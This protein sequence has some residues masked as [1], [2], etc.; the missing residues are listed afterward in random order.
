M[1]LTALLDATMV[2]VL[3]VDAD[4]DGLADPGDRIA[5]TVDLINF[6]DMDATG[7]GFDLVFDDPNLTLVPGSINVSPLARNDA[8]QAVGNTPLEVG[9]PQGSGPSVN[10]NGSLFDND[11]EFLGD[12]FALTSFDATSAFGGQVSVNPDGTFTYDPPVGFEGTDTFGYSI[13]DATTIGEGTVTIDVLDPVWY[14]DNSASPGGDGT[15]SAPFDDLAPLNSGGAAPDD[16]GDTIFLYEGVS[17]SSPYVGP[18]VLENGQDLVGQAVDLQVGGHVLVPS[19]GRPVVSGFLS[20]DAVE[21]ARDNT[22]RGLRLERANAGIRGFDVGTLSIDDVEISDTT[23]GIRANGGPT[24][25]VTIDGVQ[26]SNSGIA[27]LLD[28]GG[29]MSASITRNFLN[30]VST[31]IAFVTNTA[32]ITVDDLRGN[33]IE[34]ASN[35]GI[36][37]SGL[38]GVVFNS[39]SGGNTSISGPGAGIIVPR[40]S[41]A[42]SFDALDIRSDSGPALVAGGIGAFSLNVLDG[43]LE[44]LSDTALDLFNLSANLSTTLLSAGGDDFG[45]RLTSVDG[46]IT[47]TTTTVD[48]ALDTAVEILNSPA[49]IDLG[50]LTIDSLGADGLSVS[51][52]GS[53]RTTGGTIETGNGIG[54]DINNAELDVT[55]ESVA[56]TG[57]THGIRLDTTTGSFSVTGNGA[58]TTYV[59][60][61]DSTNETELSRNS[62]GGVFQN[63]TGH[64]VVLDD[65][66]GVTLRQM[67]LSSTGGDAIFS[68]GGGDFT[69]EALEIDMASHTGNGWMAT[70]LGGAN[71]LRGSVIENVDTAGRSSIRVSNT[72]TLLEGLDVENNTFQESQSGQS[73]V[74][75]ESSGSG[76][77]MDVGLRGNRF[78]NNTAQA[79]TGSAGQSAGSATLTSRVGGPNAGDGN[80]FGNTIPGAL[81]NNIG[82]LVANGATHEAL[83]QGNLLDDVARDGG[84]ANTSIIRTQNNGG[85]AIYEV[86]DN[87]LQNFNFTSGGRHGIGHV[88][89]PA[90]GT[91]YTSLIVDS[92]TIDDTTDREGIFI[93]FRRNMTGGD[94]TISN[95]EIGL[96]G[97]V[98]GGG[99][100]SDNEAIDIEIRNDAGL[101]YTVNLLIEQNT[102]TTTASGSREIVFVEA[103]DSTSIEATIRNNMITAGGTGNEIEVE[104]E[105]LGSAVHASISGNT[106]ASGTGRIDLDGGSGVLR[107]QQ[108][109]QSNVASVN[110][111][112][113]GNVIISGGGV[114]QFSAGSPELPSHPMISSARGLGSASAASAVDGNATSSNENAAVSDPEPA[115]AHGTSATSDGGFAGNG[116]TDISIPIGVLPPGQGVQ[117]FFEADVAS[118]LNVDAT[119]VAAQGSVTADGGISI[120]T[121]D[122]DVVGLNATVTPL[123]PPAAVAQVYVSSSRWSQSFLEEVDPDFELKNRMFVIP[124]DGS[125]DILEIDP[126]SGTELNRFVAPLPAASAS[127]GL[128]FDG[129]SLFFIRGLVS[130]VLWELDPDT[131]AVIDQDD[132]GIVSIDGIAAVGERIY[133]NDWGAGKILE[134]DPVSDTITNTIFPDSQFQGGIGGA[135]N[136]DRLLASFNFGQIL[137]FDLQAQQS[138]PLFFPPFNNVRGVAELDGE[139]YVAGGFGD[140][141]VYSPQGGI[142]RSHPLPTGGLGLAS[143]VFVEHDAVGHPVP[144]GAAQ[145]DRLAWDNVDR[146]HVVFTKDVDVDP[147]AATLLGANVPGGAYPL[148]PNLFEYDPATRTATW[149]LDTSAFPAMPYDFT[150]LE[151]DA[152]LVSDAGGV[153]LLDGDWVNPEA[154]SSG[155]SYPSGDGLAGGNFE[156]RLDF[157]VA[158]ADGDKATTIFD[159]RDVRDAMFTSIGSPAYSVDLDF[160]GNGQI[161][162]QEVQSLRH[163][164]GRLLSPGVPTVPPSRAPSITL[165][166]GQDRVISVPGAAARTGSLDVILTTGD[167]STR[168][169]LNYS[170]RVGLTGPDVGGGVALTGGGVAQTSPAAIAPMLNV[171]GNLDRLPDSYYLGTVNLFEPPLTVADGDGL[172]R[173]D[174]EVQPGALG[175]Y[176]FGVQAGGTADT[177]L[178]VNA[179]NGEELFLIAGS[180]LIVT[181]PGDLDGDFVVG[182][183]DLQIV[184]SNFTQSVPVGDYAFGDHTGPGGIPDGI[185]GADD[186]SLVLSNFTN[187]AVPPSAATEDGDGGQAGA[188]AAW[189][190]W[191]EYRQTQSQ[192]TDLRWLPE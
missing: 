149:G 88:A 82:V 18:L 84:I 14:V 183:N 97:N 103:K 154:G 76:F 10:I 71:V 85:T 8:Y 9:V 108:T 75:V 6:G 26:I 62:S 156:F 180:N 173:V 160:N 49:T 191:R 27:I 29:T 172:I 96:I 50:Q 133:L 41:G 32:A 170:V 87:V 179:S 91:G 43:Q 23:D 177:A 167:G 143:G 40:A 190:A 1:L 182:A 80:L 42:L 109:S 112:S 152:S 55:L 174:Y 59:T 163:Q 46:S 7:T 136:P 86:L 24:A 164:L 110:S 61:V 120:L 22:V 33:I 70:D 72:N 166:A 45:V 189:H 3:V 117:I 16:E 140:L 125:S 5:Y 127:D 48:D 36:Q 168:S 25:A 123:D 65:A 116:A 21:L 4:G 147:A 94:V 175:I 66:A 142:L 113:V 69:F 105:D 135:E 121:D 54:V 102:A 99:P 35:I 77:T 51:N 56:V 145:L 155:D 148:D 83:I 28:S 119:E 89:E 81:E 111:I 130:S 192:G 185:V 158:D 169:L 90:S 151:I 157:A 165:T 98:G 63:T 68:D 13:R 138:T 57:A 15:A 37:Q 60:P 134:F 150:L 92:N 53:L 141:F 128:A 115:S 186:L 38:N 31:G 30:T 137:E 144:D 187:M 122:P 67:D 178:I 106:L 124:F 47:S 39:A 161:T 139:I 188:L 171:D 132:L 101:A 100:L 104:A 19:S 118:P 11:S 162:D 126:L 74:L 34:N 64:A 107:V 17:A 20:T 159:I 52:S 78:L 93:N 131:G 2:D 79:Y 12:A 58:T 129:T 181:I 95:N 44:S 184:L 146:F 153:A 176:S 73:V 114:D